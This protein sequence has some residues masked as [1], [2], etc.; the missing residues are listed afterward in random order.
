MGGSEGATD[1]PLLA[2]ENRVSMR[3]E[4]ARW[5]VALINM[6]FV[7]HGRPS[8]Q[9]GLLKPLAVSHGFPVD[10]YHLNLDFAEQIG[11]DVYEPLCE[12]AGRDFVGDWLFSLVAFGAEAPDRSNEFLTVYADDIERLLSL[13]GRPLEFLLKLRT[14]EVPRYL[15]HLLQV[16]PWH[17]YRVVGFT[18]TFQQNVASF[19]LARLLKERF[20]SLTIVFG[21][22][23]FDG[24]MG[25][26]WVRATSFIDL[27]V[28][29]E[30]DIAF[31]QLLIALQEGRD[32]TEI[33][34]VVCA[35]NPRLPTSW[36]PMAALDELPEPDYDEFFTRA[37]S[38]GL[39]EKGPSRNVPLPFESAR[40]CWWGE[41]H[42]CTFCGLNGLSMKFRSKSPLRVET[43][44]MNAVRRYRSW[45]FAA[46]DNIL[47]MSYLKTF[48]PSIVDN[49][50]D[51]EFFYEIKANL[52]RSHIKLLSQAG[53]K[54]I[55]PGIE[56]LSSHVL[57]LMRKGTTSIQNV[58]L[59]RWALYYGI[60]V[61]WNCLYGFPGENLVDYLDQFSLM[62]QVPHLE[63]PTGVQRIWMERFSPVFFDRESFPVEYLRPQSSYQYIYPAGVDLEAVAYFFE[64]SFA[65]VVS[66]SELESTRELINVWRKA[67]H[68]SERPTL[69]FRS[70]GKFVQIED[71]RD[72]SA[73]GTYT[74]VDD[75][76]AM[77][78]SLSDRPRSAAAI[79]ERLG[80]QWPV[81]EVECALEEF[82]SRGLMMRDGDLFLSLAIPKTRSR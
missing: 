28:V 46:V 50:A 13:M 60:K 51:Y 22:A 25:V 32:P 34:G 77:Y 23:N 63:P 38:L 69:T 7:S 65:D 43:E 39:I 72:V 55:Q 41:K 76:G 37:E 68:S 75:L 59:L 56:S 16:V 15:E 47:D 18:S 58:N 20:P 26:E 71:L 53:V 29:G 45:K 11:S 36:A 66:D 48:L 67:W 54:H 62:Q 21:G 6:P 19:S 82:R 78:A 17:Q 27:A 3:Q 64:Y 61:S 44:L 52:N 2:L 14:E 79:K 30:G 73:P 4:R 1:P 10:T 9:L 35:R 49:G 40:G 24:S 81:D 57:R 74:F 12:Y 42:H 31:P 80:L 8:I 33:P 5:P 70:T